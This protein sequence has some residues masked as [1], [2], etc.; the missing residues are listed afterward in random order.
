MFETMASKIR[1]ARWLVFNPKIPILGKFW[2]ALDWKTF[3]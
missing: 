1:V 3:I 2:R